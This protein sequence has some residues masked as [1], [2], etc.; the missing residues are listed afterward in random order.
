[1]NLVDK[2]VLGTAQFGM[3]YG[4]NNSRGQVTPAEVNEILTEAGKAGMHFIDTAYGY[5]NSEDVLGSSSALHSKK[6]KIISKYGAEGLSPIEQYGATLSR[7]KV[8]KLYAYLVH[9]FPTYSENPQI[10]KEFKN[11]KEEDR[12][13]RIGFSL[14]SPNELEYIL[15]HD[16]CIDIVQVP[17][18][19]LDRQFEKWFPVLHEKGIEVHT[20][21]V[22]LQGLFFKDPVT[23]SGNI[24]PLALY[25]EEIQQYC[26]KNNIQI[27]DLALGYV[28]SSLTDGVLIGVDSLNQL[29]NNIKSACRAISEQELNFIRS[30]NVKEKELLSP[31]NW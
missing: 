12:V 26:H 4:V 21:S 20:R 19:I 8:D 10:W 23:F 2:L 5:G 25:V 1:M 22:F 27:Q 11:L 15:E 29:R 16:L 18:N 6:F 31:V 7:L 9:N 14:Y 3:D 24:T 28:L 17:Y 30:I 13:E